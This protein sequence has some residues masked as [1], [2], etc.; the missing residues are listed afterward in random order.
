MGTFAS[1]KILCCL[2]SL[3]T[4]YSFNRTRVAI[5]LESGLQCWK[6]RFFLDPEFSWKFDER[7]LIYI[8]VTLRLNLISYKRLKT[9]QETK[10]QLAL[11]G[12]FSKTF[13]I[14]LFWLLYFFHK[15]WKKLQ[16]SLKFKTMSPF[17]AICLFGH[18]CL[19]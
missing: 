16:V 17:W 3:L 18:F 1:F 8:G 6:S 12:N 15:F 7:K 10:R 14:A 2:L 5:F 19:L 9:H 11:K 13:T 4:S